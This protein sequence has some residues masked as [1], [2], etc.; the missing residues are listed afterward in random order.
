M[1]QTFHNKSHMHVGNDA[2]EGWI[3]YIQYMYLCIIHDLCAGK[4]VQQSNESQ[5]LVLVNS[6]GFLASSPRY[7]SP[8][9]AA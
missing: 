4:E 5:V 7:R 6:Q 9:S 1:I 2:E 3:I 8:Q